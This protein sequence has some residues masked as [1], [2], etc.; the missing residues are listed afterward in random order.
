M[1]YESSVRRLEAGSSFPSLLSTHTQTHTHTHTRARAR[2]NTLYQ[3]YL[4]KISSALFLGVGLN[5]ESLFSHLQNGINNAVS[6]SNTA[7]ILI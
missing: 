7:D 6:L 3:G 5:F 2:T 4:S 1:T